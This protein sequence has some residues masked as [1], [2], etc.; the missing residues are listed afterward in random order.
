M[1]TEKVPIEISELSMMLDSYRVKVLIKP[2]R[3]YWPV[4]AAPVSEA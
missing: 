1:T 4:A 2:F 3:P